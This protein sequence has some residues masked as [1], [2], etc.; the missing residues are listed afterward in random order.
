MSNFASGVDDSAQAVLGTTNAL[1]ST[2]MQLLATDQIQPGSHPSYQI[3]KTIFTDHPLGAKMAEAPIKLAQSQEREIQIPGSPEKELKEAFDKEWGQIGGTG[4]DLIIRNTMTLAR[5]YGI[6]SVAVLED[7]KDTEKPLQMDKLYEAD[8]SFNTLDPLNTA[9]SLVL[10]QDPNSES[11]MKPK[12]IR[13]GAKNYHSSRTVILMNEQ[14]VYIQWTNSA[15]GFVGRSVYQR[16]LYPLKSYIQSMITDN[17]VIE[18]AGLIVAKMKSP[19]SV[20]DQNA[21]NWFG[22]KRQAIKGA[23][24]GNVVS[25]GVDETL[26]SLDLGHLRDATEFARN[27]ILK[28]IATAADMPASL[29]NQ[30][31]LAEGFG[32]GS[33]DAKNIAR[34]IDGVRL[35]AA[36]IY[37]FF[38][39]IVMHRAW[40]PD[41]YKTIQAKY[42][43]VYGDVPYET[44]FYEWKNSFAAKWP[45]LLAE[46]D[47]KKR[48]G[49][50]VILKAMIAAAEVMLPELDPENKANVIE[51]MQDTINN[52]K[53]M[54]DSHLDID[55]DALASY[56]P[57][58]PP[59]EPN[60]PT[61]ESSRT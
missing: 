7:G 47:S 37:D 9:G 51:W 55:Y 42:P 8:L 3:C 52:R 21:R 15:F 57:P 26:E 61:P 31:T 13:V 22:F 60:E 2:L 12:Y 59:E 32:E 44:A 53:F 25:I 4:A 29:I 56:V 46:P 45:N 58:E 35:D 33:E 43:D 36:P 19:G 17:L 38:D 54:F 24:T 6:S 48:E 16:A 11:F 49:D 30:E 14:P 50:D 1:P 34:F 40:N 10:D 18:K 27:N 23:K 5:V 39:K 20:I 41:F 28:N